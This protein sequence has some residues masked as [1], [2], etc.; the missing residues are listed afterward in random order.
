VILMPCQGMLMS[1]HAPATTPYCEPH[2]ALGP[3]FI[4]RDQSQSLPAVAPSRLVWPWLS[5]A[6]RPRA[7][8]R[9]RWGIKWQLYIGTSARIV[10]RRHGLAKAH[11]EVL[12]SA[13]H[14]SIDATLPP[15]GGHQ[16]TESCRLSTQSLMR[17][18][19]KGL[20]SH[21]CGTTEAVV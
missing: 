3:T 6:H 19:R 17:V 1:P 14:D 20:R 12:V 10:T 4:S 11:H 5:Q 7:P 8:A 15:R 21:A 16:C 2:P 13:L 18:M 9:V